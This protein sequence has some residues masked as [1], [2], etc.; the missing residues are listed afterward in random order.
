MRAV[1]ERNGW[2]D[3][4]MDAWH[5]RST[6]SRW[7]FR[8][9]IGGIAAGAIYASCM[10]GEQGDFWDKLFF[11]DSAVVS[12]VYGQV[13][14]KGVTELGPDYADTIYWLRIEQCRADVEAAIKGDAEQRSFNPVVGAIGE[15]CYVDGVEV[16][17]ETYQNTTKGGVIRFRGSP[18]E[19]LPN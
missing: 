12:G 10:A 9:V 11:D 1:K 15:G 6:R 2:S 17:Q 14:D 7:K 4:F 16:S 3:R 8:A 5:D 13:E 18:T 19:H